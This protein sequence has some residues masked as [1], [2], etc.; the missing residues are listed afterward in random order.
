MILTDLSNTKKNCGEKF[1]FI[2][3]LNA[4]QDQLKSQ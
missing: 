1:R 3:T 4:P 2:N